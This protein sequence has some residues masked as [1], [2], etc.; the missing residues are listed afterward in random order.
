MNITTPDSGCLTMEED[1][2]II[3][4]LQLDINHDV[5]HTTDDVT[6][7][8]IPPLDLSEVTSA[9]EMTSSQQQTSIVTSQSVMN[10]K[11]LSSSNARRKRRKQHSNDNKTVSYYFCVNQCYS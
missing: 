9:D 7:T 6:N 2:I 10:N 11:K 5:I 3:P 4:K 1:I 8:I